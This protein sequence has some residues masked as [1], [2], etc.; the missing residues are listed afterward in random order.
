MSD[1]GSYDECMQRAKQFASNGLLKKALAALMRAKELDDNEKVRRRIQKIRELLDEE[2]DEATD[3]E[4]E[5]EPEN[6]SGF[7]TE[8]NDFDS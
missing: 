6:T 1:F 7:R 5:Q 3:S 8:F 4:V 2:S